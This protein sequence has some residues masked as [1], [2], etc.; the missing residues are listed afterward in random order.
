M[1]RPCRPST[2][3]CETSPTCEPRGHIRQLTKHSGSLIGDR[4]RLTGLFSS[5]NRCVAPYTTSLQNPR[6]RRPTI[7][8]SSQAVNRVNGTN[9]A[10]V[11][12]KYSLS[13]AAYLGRDPG[14]QSGQHRVLDRTV[15]QL[16]VDQIAWM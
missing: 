16:S 6:A 5:R 7:R 15:A 12:I 13:A 2:S 1:T 11:A 14:E 4:S 10:A 8:Q 3:G 9:R